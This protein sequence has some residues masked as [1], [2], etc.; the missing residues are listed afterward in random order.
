MFFQTEKRDAASALLKK[1]GLE[2]TD[3]MGLVQIYDS[4]GG[5]GVAKAVEL[6][7]AEIKDQPQFMQEAS[8]LLK[9][10]DDDSSPNE[11]AAKPSPVLCDVRV[12]G[13]RATGT[14]QL[15]DSEESTPVF[16]KKENG[17]WVITSEPI[18]KDPQ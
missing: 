12:D 4:P 15:P 6:V 2:K 9:S 13:D 14:L 11:V 3:I 1:N 8:A 17:S 16:F 5:K 18:K 7:G 10:S